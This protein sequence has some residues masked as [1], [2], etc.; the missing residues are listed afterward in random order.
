M[1]SSP[2]GSPRPSRLALVWRRLWPRRLF[3]R[4]LIIVVAPMVL[5]QAVIAYLYLNQQEA[6][7]T[8]FL[9]RGVASEIDL[10]VDL[11]GRETT[12]QGRAA[13]ARTASNESDMTVW[14]EPGASLPAEP[15]RLG[16]AP[17][18]VLRDELA[19]RLSE[20]YWI[21]YQR[22]V[23]RVDV[24]VA[25][26]G[27]VL[28]FEPERK[29][30][31]NI[32]MHLFPVW[33]LVFSLIFLAVALLFLRN[34]VR[35]IQRL[36]LAAEAF[37]RGRDVPDFKPQG[38][39]EVRQAA[40]AFLDMRERIAR[41][42]QQRTEMLAGV[43]HDLRTPLTRMKLELA[44]MPDSAELDELREDV[45]EMERML[46][47]YLAF[48]RGEGGEAAAE[49]DIGAL[50]EEAADDARRKAQ[51]QKSAAT[52]GV[53][54]EGDLTAAVKRNAL[55]RCLTNLVENALRYGRR[56]ELAASRD[57]E[58]ILITVDDDGPGIPA[59]LREEA[60]KPFRRLDP[61]RN[62]DKA[63]WAWASP[64]PA[65]SRAAMAATWGSRTGPSAA[66][67]RRCG[68]RLRRAPS[69]LGPAAAARPSAASAEPAAP[70]GRRPER[71]RAR[72][73]TRR[74]P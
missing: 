51:A 20:P 23:E 30:L 74:R 1:S 54:V 62:L 24:R 7:T 37:G 28:R 18:E 3:A 71:A 42:I 68:S 46:E 47:E 22:F 44:M 21:D 33:S 73:G 15:S 31:V 53:A 63:A 56:A 13:V 29:R 6:R 19:Q 72:A 12:D 59:E 40:I 4:A 35:P 61:S 65:T 26:G 25:S 38:A 5:L 57:S 70:K 64:S 11:A 39:T 58:G 10:V 52:V 43:S 48:A 41:Q 27:G 66:C 14:F 9:T 36:A 67:G 17:A 8:Q 45:A 49:T 16:D 2:T 69:S 34:Q 60:F 50:V 55:K 32:N